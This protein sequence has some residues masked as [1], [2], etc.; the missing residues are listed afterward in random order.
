VQIFEVK[1]LQNPID[2]VIRICNHLTFEILSRYSKHIS[3]L[4]NT[5]TCMMPD[6]ILKHLRITQ[7]LFFAYNENPALFI[8]RITLF[9]LT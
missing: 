5:D 4:S 3:M 9:E 8:P 6:S 1:I 2:I 7:Y